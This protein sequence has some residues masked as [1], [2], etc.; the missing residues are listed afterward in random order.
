MKLSF[1]R[2][3]QSADERFKES[4]ERYKKALDQN[5]G[6]VRIYI[7]IAELYLE[8]NKKEQAI[9]QYLLAA[10][11][12]Q[13]KR[14]L[15]IAVAIY[16]HIITVDPDRVDVYRELAAL[17]LKNGFIGDSVAVLEK[18]AHYFYAKNME[19]EAVQVL[20]QI[21]EID[22]SNEFFKIKVEKFYT[23]KE[24]SEDAALRVGPRDKWQLVGKQPVAAPSPQPQSEGTFDL[25][26][27]LSEDDAM[28]FSISTL[29]PE[30]L[31]TSEATSCTAAPDAIFKELKDSV[32]A[33]PEKDSPMFHYNLGLAY[34]RC[35]DDAHAA[36]EFL[37]ALPG[38][39]DKASCY[40]RL[41]YCLARLKRFDEAHTHIAA[42]LR[43][44]S[45]SL[46][47]KLDLL[48]C[49]GMIYKEQGDREQALKVFKKIYA[50]DKQY[51][52]VAREIHELS[53]GIP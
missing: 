24:L 28:T 47:H 19:F 4:L 29:E 3:K 13:E 42:A 17:H 2:K 15:Q 20:N 44:P 32:A 5:P 33:S 30:S 51:K 43:L 8:H 45:L 21:K 7:K 38:I 49:A 52:S 27:A 6:D 37:I 18:L 34:E 26:A 9:E 50:A 10:R 11:A 36:E 23:A 46:E 22:P 53:S 14:L 1:F 25:A 12:Y 48:Y 39:D 41:V 35:N 40:V 31:D 16:N